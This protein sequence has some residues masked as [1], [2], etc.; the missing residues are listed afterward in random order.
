MTTIE[1][2]AREA[3]VKAGINEPDQ[4]LVDQMVLQL[5]DLIKKN[6]KK[7]VQEAFSKFFEAAE[8]TIAA[9]SD[10]NQ[11]SSIGTG[12][13]VGRPPKESKDSPAGTATAKPGQTQGSPAADGPPSES[14]GTKKAGEAA[15]GETKAGHEQAPE[16]VPA[17]SKSS[18]ADNDQEEE[19]K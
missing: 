7:M 17:E 12:K 18:D 11:A 1:Q 6:L 16:D 8:L 19:G 3:L 4:N 15:L 13:K 2:L 9:K 5:H 10:A 14:S